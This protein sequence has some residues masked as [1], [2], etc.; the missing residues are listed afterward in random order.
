MLSNPIMGLQFN[1]SSLGFQPGR[2]DGVVG[3]K[4]RSAIA[5][6]Y[7]H[8]GQYKEPVDEGSAVLRDVRD[9]YG[10]SSIEAVS[11]TADELRDIWIRV[12]RREPS[13]IVY[14]RVS[15]I[16]RA[17]KVG[18]MNTLDRAAHF[19]GQIAHESDGFNVVEE[20]ADGSA[21]QGRRDLGNL[22]P[23]DGKRF[24]GRGFIQLTG[25]NNYTRYGD[26]LDVDFVSDP[27]MVT[28][29]G[30]P[31]LVSVLYWA[32]HNLNAIADMGD[33]EPYEPITRAINGG[34]N[35]F[36]DRVVWTQMTWIVLNG[37]KADEINQ[38]QEGQ[39]CP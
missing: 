4:T 38:P 26:L 27:E 24:K 36:A 28:Q 8:R 1:L 15:A 31:G 17:L 32:D 34:T 9:A 20:Y 39:S 11:I 7:G 21:Y 16:N 37:R 22:Q 14:T 35:G 18:A 10:L 33:G 12:R 5:A 30:Y 6:F 19:I 3:S 29:G 23:G 13:D 25:R 2:I